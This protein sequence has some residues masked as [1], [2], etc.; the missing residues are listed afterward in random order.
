MSI[1]KIPN[2][3]LVVITFMVLFVNG[4]FINAQTI[5]TKQYSLTIAEN[6]KAV[7]F[8]FPCFPCDKENTKAEAHFLKYTSQNGISTV[9]LNYNQK[10][11]L[12]KKDKKKLTKQLNTII[13]KHG[14]PEK[15]LFIGGFSG[16]GNVTTLLANH[17]IKTN[18]T[19][20][21]KGIFIVDAPVDLE[22]LY[23]TAKNDIQQNADQDAVDEGR[24]L[25]QLF[26]E[27]LGNP[28]QNSVDYQ[29]YSPYLIQ[30]NS[31][32]NIQFLKTIKVRL[33]TEPDLKWQSEKKKRTYL[34]LNA[35]KLEKMHE[36]LIG[37]GSTK[38]EF[39][40]TENLG[41]RANGSR[42]PH[43]WNIVEPESLI[44]WILE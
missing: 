21:P 43:S 26:N 2:T 22:E 7:L 1:H 5:D 42:H 3:M 19:T 11:F 41:Y 31:V 4:V 24:F 23:R 29:K 30:G 12:T 39:I 33:Y 28:D 17:L 34:D 10:L 14:L 40:K 36:A 8:L 32:T 13:K 27:K 35:Y 6:Q 25:V 16:G 37:L 15:A 38:A 20:Q 9:L 44:Q 18:N